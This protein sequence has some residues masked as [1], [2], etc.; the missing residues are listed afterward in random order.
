MSAFLSYRAGLQTRKINEPHRRDCLE[1]HTIYTYI[2]TPPARTW[3]NGLDLLASARIE[4]EC[5]CTAAGVAREN[6]RS[7]TLPPTTR[8]LRVLLSLPLVHA[9]SREPPL[10]R[11]ATRAHVYIIYK[12]AYTCY[13][14]LFVNDSEPDR[15]VFVPFKKVVLAW[16]TTT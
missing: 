3:N 11:K 16:C 9:A 4:G 6:S 10:A 12:N 7:L 14:C 1:T 5:V 2:S 8:K 13:F 15:A